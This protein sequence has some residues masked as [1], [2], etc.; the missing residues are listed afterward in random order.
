MDQ[1]GVLGCPAEYKS[2]HC[3]IVMT[4]FPNILIMAL[5][6]PTYLVNREEIKEDTTLRPNL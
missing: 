3:T 4:G 6:Q 2:V 5:C 1:E